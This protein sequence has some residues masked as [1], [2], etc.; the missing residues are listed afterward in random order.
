MLAD[1]KYKVDVTSL[2]ASDGD[3]MFAYSHTATVP[4]SSQLTDAGVVFY[5]QRRRRTATGSGPHA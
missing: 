5:A 2:G 1:A 4:G 3:Q